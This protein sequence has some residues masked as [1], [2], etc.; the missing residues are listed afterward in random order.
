MST[1]EDTKSL[2]FIISCPFCGEFEQLEVVGTYSI[3]RSVQC[4]VCGTRGPISLCDEGAI[5][6]WNKQIASKSELHI[7]RDVPF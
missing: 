2:P 3:A 4:K 5:R 6:L 1:S 7:H